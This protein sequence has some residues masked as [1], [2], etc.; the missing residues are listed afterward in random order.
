MNFRNNVS[1]TGTFSVTSSVTLNGGGTSV[2]P[3]TND[4]SKAIATT[5]WVKSQGYT[6]GST[7]I[8]SNGDITSVDDIDC[9]FWM[10]L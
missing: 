10:G 2:T 5:E 9:R 8:T 3:S 1:V 7:G 6:S 4:N